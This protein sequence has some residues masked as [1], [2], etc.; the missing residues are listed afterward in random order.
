M[1]RTAV[2]LSTVVVGAGR[3]N[4][5]VRDGEAAVRQCENHWIV[6]LLPADR[7][8][9][10]K[11]M[12]FRPT[13][14]CKYDAAYRDAPVDRASPTGREATRLSLG[15]IADQPWRCVPIPPANMTSAPEVAPFPS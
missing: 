6:F 14:R 9:S 13:S 4:V 3:E 15:R 10:G 5:I 7:P 8:P 2:D 11:R 12:E 1:S